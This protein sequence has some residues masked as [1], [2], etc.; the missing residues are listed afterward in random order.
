MSRAEI[1]QFTAE[2]DVGVITLDYRFHTPYGQ[3]IAVTYMENQLPVLAATDP[4]TDFRNFC[5]K[6]T[7]GYGAR[8]TIFFF[9]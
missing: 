9:L 2:S 3:E 8:Q 4:A 7:V 1:E 6:T 5:R